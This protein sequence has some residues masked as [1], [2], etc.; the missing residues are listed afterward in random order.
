MQAEGEGAVT[1][2]ADSFSGSSVLQGSRR[3]GGVCLSVVV[4]CPSMETTRVC[5]LQG[6][7]EWERC[8]G[9]EKG[10]RC[11]CSVP[12][13]AEGWGQRERVGCK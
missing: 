13:K 9:G 12:A 6:S 8:L 4:V 11:R 3:W 5:V 1:G 7:V 2:D 10:Y